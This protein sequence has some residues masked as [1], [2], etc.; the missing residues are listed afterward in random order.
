MSK[1]IFSLFN[2]RINFWLL[3]FISREYLKHW[4]S[5]PR[6]G[7]ENDFISINFKKLKTHVVGFPG[8]VVNAFVIGESQRVFFS[9]VL[10]QPESGCVLPGKLWK[11]RKP[12]HC[13]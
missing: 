3:Q 1:F 4:S 9:T 6:G 12:C 8:E 7:R 13:F 11:P 2:T 5:E 10:R